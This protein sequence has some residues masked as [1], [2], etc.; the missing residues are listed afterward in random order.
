MTYGTTN[1]PDLDDVL[2]ELERLKREG[3]WQKAV[4]GLCMLMLIADVAVSLLGQRQQRVVQAA[5]FE[6]VDARGKKR[7]CLEMEKSGP[8]LTLNDESGTV[9]ALLNLTQ[10]ESGLHL[11]DMAGTARAGLLS[12]KKGALIGV[13]D[14]S[15][16]VRAALGSDKGG[17]GMLVYD[18]DGNNVWRTP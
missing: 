4:I 17:A 5:G 15:G 9:R 7:A 6:L 16:K 13:S 11:C 8:R 1:T 10:E 2:V 12:S 14:A 18:E 3:R